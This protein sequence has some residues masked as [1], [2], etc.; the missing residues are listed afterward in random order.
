LPCSTET[1]PVRKGGRSPGGTPD[2]QTG[3]ASAYL[4]QK[5]RQTSSLGG[6]S[7]KCQ[8]IK[9][10]F[11]N[12][13]GMIQMPATLKFH[14]IGNNAVG[15]KLED[16]TGFISTLTQQETALETLVNAIV[17]K[18]TQTIWDGEDA[19]KFESIYGEQLAQEHKKFKELLEKMKQIIET[20]KGDQQTTSTGGVS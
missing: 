15:A 10:C 2:I 6:G 8:P 9:Q 3:L 18:S 16:M 11:L 14:T 12:I 7:S 17:Q 1:L 20:N 13:K 4:I 5:Q 19:R